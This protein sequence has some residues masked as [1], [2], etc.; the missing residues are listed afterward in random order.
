MVDRFEFASAVTIPPS[1]CDQ[2]KEHTSFLRAAQAAS[3]KYFEICAAEMESQRDLR[4]CLLEGYKHSAREEPL[5]RQVK[6]LDKTL[7]IL[8]PAESEN[9][10]Q[11]LQ[12]EGQEG[13]APEDASEVSEQSRT[14]TARRVI[15]CVTLVCTNVQRGNYH[16]TIKPQVGLLRRLFA[17]FRY[18]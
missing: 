8:K 4:A 17:G 15:M 6:T 3:L 14:F 7:E 10:R 12:S 2:Q 9:V 13:L 16:E 1:E 5:R 18:M 11:G